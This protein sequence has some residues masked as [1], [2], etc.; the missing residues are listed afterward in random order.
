MRS[1]PM[2]LTVITALL[3]AACGGRGTNAA[4]SAGAGEEPHEAV[5]S[6]AAQVI[7]LSD[8]LIRFRG[9]DTVDMGRMRSGETVSRMLTVR[10]A[11]DTP[12]VIVDID[13]TCGCVDVDYPRRPLKA[14][15]QAPMQLEF[16]SR[17]INGWVYKTLYIKTSSPAGNYTLV[18]TAD[19]D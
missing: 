3:M 6:S 10:N 12:L 18:V 17:G 19:V 5:V 2:T 15:E 14:G 8:S 1:L 11:G 4:A 7:A 13:K 9:A 16:D